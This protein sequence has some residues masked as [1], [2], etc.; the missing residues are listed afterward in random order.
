M[1]LR[2]CQTG[3]MLLIFVLWLLMCFSFWYHIGDD[4]ALWT[5]KVILLRDKKQYLLLNLNE[6]KKDGWEN[7]KVFIGNRPAG[8]KVRIFLF[9][10]FL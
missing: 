6:K 8:Y 2:I 1:T 7:A 10:L 9:Q 3:S 5:L 4:K